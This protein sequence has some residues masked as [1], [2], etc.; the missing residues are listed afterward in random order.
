MNYADYDTLREE[1][2][3][4]NI[5]AVDF[6]TQQSQEMTED[7]EFFCKDQGINPKSESS[8]IAFMAYQDALFEESRSN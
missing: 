6:V 5:T 4:K 8:A 2:E 3:A 7:Y 1:Y